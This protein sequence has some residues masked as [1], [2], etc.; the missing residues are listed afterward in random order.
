[1]IS[2][3][4]FLSFGIYTLLFL[5]I[6]LSTSLYS[7][8]LSIFTPACFISSTVFTTLLSFTF[9]CLTLSSKSTLSTIIS[10]F[11]VFLTTNYSGFTN[12]S[13]SL[14]LSMLISKSSLLLRLSA[15]SILLPKTCF[16]IERGKR[17]VYY[18]E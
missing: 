2:T 8:F 10:I 11:S 3:L 12:V 16:N 4:N 17:V 1:M 13:F 7:L 18:D 6:I 15:F 14:S 5:Y 9:N